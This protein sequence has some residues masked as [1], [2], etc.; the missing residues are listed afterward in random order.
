[1]GLNKVQYKKE[2]IELHIKQHIASVKR[3]SRANMET[4]ETIFHDI[5]V[6]IKKLIRKHA[7]LLDILIKQKEQEKI[8]PIF[9]PKKTQKKRRT[10]KSLFLKH[11]KEE[12]KNEEFKRADKKKVTTKISSNIVLSETERAETTNKLIESE[13]DNKPDTDIYNNNNLIKENENE[14]KNKK[15]DKY[16]RKENISFK[17]TFTINNLFKNKTNSEIITNN[18]KY[19]ENSEIRRIKAEFNNIDDSKKITPKKGNAQFFKGLVGYKS[20]KKNIYINN[21]N[22]K[23]L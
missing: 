10:F 17:K 19:G 8:N 16:D 12:N 20:A 4:Y 3:K 14:D 15:K 5:I 7:I 6:N 2:E 23:L 1:M 13:E 11:K 9:T 18:D 21:K 22:G